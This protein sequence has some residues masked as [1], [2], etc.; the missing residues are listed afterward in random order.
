M[1][2]PLVSHFFI[3][4]DFNKL[5]KVPFLMR[6]GNSLLIHQNNTQY[7]VRPP[8]YGTSCGSRASR[9]DRAGMSSIAAFNEESSKLQLNSMRKQ[10]DFNCIVLLTCEHYGEPGDDTAFLKQF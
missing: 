5:C 6:E 3:K 10:L 2:T 4:Y 7:V 1:L 9:L 8:V